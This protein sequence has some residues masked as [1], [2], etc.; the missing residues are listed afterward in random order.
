MIDYEPSSVEITDQ[1]NHMDEEEDPF[2]KFIDYAQLILKE[3]E[4]DNSDGPGWSWIASR[5]LKACVAYS[6][7]VTPAILLS[8]LSQAWN[9]QNRGRAPKK[10]P[11]CINQL[12]EKHRRAKLP[13][14]V[15]IDS[16]YEKRFLSLTSVIEAV[17]IDAYCLPGTNICMITLG[18]FWSS[19]TIDLY[20]HRRFYKLADP[21]NGI[22]KKGREAFLTGCHLRTASKSCGQARLLPTEYFV[23]LL[24]ED[25]DDDAM[26]IGA[27]FCSDSFS[28]ISLEAVKEE[29]SYSLYA[30]IESIG[31]LETQKYGNLQKKQITLVDNDGVKLKFLLWGEQV[32]LSNLFSV[33][34]M[35]A[36]DRPFIASSSN[37]EIETCEEIFLEYG[38]ATQLFMVPSIQH[39]ERV[40]VS[41]TQSRSQGSKLLN[42]S[43]QRSVISQVTLP[44]DSQ[45]SIDFSLCPFRSFVVDLRDKMTGLSLYGVVADIVHER[46][47]ARTTF[48]LKLK[49]I[50][51]TIWIKLYF[52][53]SWSLGRLG[54]GHT[55]YIS[56]LTSST[57]RG[58]RIISSCFCCMLDGLQLSW[59]ESDIGASFI[60]ISCL[61]ALLNS[62]CLHKLSR[63][64]DLSIR[65]GV[66]HICRIWL[67]Q[68]EYCH[69]STRFSH[70]LC[71][72]FV[73][74]ALGGDLFCNFCNWNCSAEVVR[75]FHLKITLADE[76]AK[77]FAW[78]TG[79]TAAELLQISLDD[80][81]ELSEEEQIL[82][83]SSLEN[84]RFIVAI[85][86]CRSDDGGL[87]N[88]EH[89][90]TAWEVTRATTV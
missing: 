41:L 83:P 42:L 33:G 40:S 10:R 38:S 32:M 6:S 89:E 34:S 18:D 3:T 28:S 20:L 76:S 24:D 7:G 23:V 64:S 80:F 47:T 67:D 88:A 5:I 1:P 14:T 50:T 9:E 55:V 59:L 81:D 43:D 51:G 49:D 61:P 90:K 56:G 8:D 87:I 85:V 2:L 77:V 13:S 48:S 60:N 4:N 37:G 39:E 63:L 68:I 82:Y 53:G 70:S 58:N 65:I 27:Q 21:N 54:L 46:N 19:N 26:L 22:L 16:I 35:L 66:T 75:S 86:S 73:D 45:G 36:L 72:N 69:V 78:C 57:S 62:S 30:R 79:Q 15:T 44:C 17:I 71:G 12:K 84:E 29:V 25:Q 52:V 74:E 11:E 31:S